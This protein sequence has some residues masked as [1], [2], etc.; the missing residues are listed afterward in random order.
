MATAVGAPCPVC[1]FP[2]AV[3]SEGQR[4]VCAYCGEKLES[5]SQGITVPTPLFVGVIMFG[6]G[7]LLGPSIIA[8]T[9]SGQQ[10]LERKARGG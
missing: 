2:V 10:W 4:T 9:K 3:E 8:S 1:G 5:I 7:I 6:L